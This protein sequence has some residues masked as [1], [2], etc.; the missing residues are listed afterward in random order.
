MEALTAK[1]NEII[2]NFKAKNHDLLDTNSNKFDRDWVEFNV[3]ISVL[4]M[5]L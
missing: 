5:N 2:K 4:D 1:F 3:E